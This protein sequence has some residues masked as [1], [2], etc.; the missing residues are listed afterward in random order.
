M[1]SD[2]KVE[3]TR[4][5]H[6]PGPW[7]VSDAYKDSATVIDRDGFEIADAQRES[8]LS[9]W[10]EVCPD[11]RHWAQDKS[12]TTRLRSKAEWL[13]NARLIAAAP[14]LLAAAAHALEALRV[15]N[16]IGRLPSGGESVGNAA[17]LEQ[18]AS[19]L[20]AAIAKAQP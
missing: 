1:S 14:E 2:T 19:E 13:A 12:R 7:A 10:P 20:A 18:I 11:L 4:A 8:I 9:N 17:H 5:Q 16:R 15:V 3:A 6:T